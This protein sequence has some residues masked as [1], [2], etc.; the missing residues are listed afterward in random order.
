MSDEHCPR[1]GT[2]VHHWLVSEA[3]RCRW[4]G[5]A[6]QTAADVLR[7]ASA[8]CGRTVPGREIQDAVRSAFTST[9]HPPGRASAPRWTGRFAVPP[10]APKWPAPD[11]KRIGEIVAENFGLADLWEASRIRLEDND[12]HTEAIVDRLFPGNPLLC[13]GKYEEKPDGTLYTAFD[14]RPRE[15]WRGQL[16]ALE[17]I[18]PSPM[19]ALT[20]LTKEGRKSKHT[21]SNTGPRRFLVCE[22]DSGSVDHHAAL[23]LHLG[24]FAPLVCA[25]HSGGKSLHGWFFVHGQPDDKVLR[26]FQYAVSLG[27]DDATW[28]RSQFVRMPDGWRPNG[29]LP[30]DGKHVGTG[31]P[32]PRRQTVFFLNF[33]ALEV[34][35]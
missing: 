30:D 5:L 20:G 27:A 9:W 35:R 7:E 25:V 23:L 10:T 33:K 26:F 28:S 32:G 12:A 21:L 3:N 11:A 14:T 19:S 4:R 24:Q 13:C 17:L 1:A 18:V 16:A 8:G 15:K 6:P 31:H 34:A 29:W 22:F 2:G